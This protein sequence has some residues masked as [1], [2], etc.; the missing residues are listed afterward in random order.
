MFLEKVIEW[1]SRELHIIERSK[2]FSE[3]AEL[4]RN[5]IKKIKGMQV[6]SMVSP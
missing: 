4:Y 1:I 5:K 2:V 6:L 3:F